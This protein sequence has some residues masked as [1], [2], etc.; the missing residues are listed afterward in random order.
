MEGSG[1]HRRFESFEGNIMSVV[2]ELMQGHS[3]WRNIQDIIR[4]TFKAMAD[5]LR[6][7]SYQIR[8]LEH[9]VAY[10]VSKNEFTSALSH[11]ADILE[12]EDFKD[13][14][15]NLAPYQASLEDKVSRSD[16]QYL[17]TNKASIEEVK[18]MLDKKLSLRDFESHLHSFHSRL[19]E[20]NRK[21]NSLPS[22]KDFQNLNSSIQEKATWADVEEALENKAN[23][24]SVANALHRK[25]N[26]SDAESLLS[27]KAD[28]EAIKELYE[29]IQTKAEKSD[30]EDIELTLDSKADKSE[31][32]AEV[33][34]ELAQKADRN[35]FEALSKDLR[36]YLDKSLMD[37]N[38]VLESYVGAMKS[39]IEEVKKSLNFNLNKKIDSKELEK[40]YNSITKKADFES[41]LEMFEKHKSEVREQ[42]SE[43]ETNTSYLA[44]HQ[45]FI[46]YKVKVDDELNKLN[47]QLKGLM[48]DRRRSSEEV[49]KYI[50]AVNS[51]NKNEVYKQISQINEHLESFDVR[52]DDLVSNR[53]NKEEVNYLKQAVKSLQETKLEPKELQDSMNK[54]Y[55]DLSDHF[56]TSCNK[57]KE[58]IISHEKETGKALEE[59]PNNEEFYKLIDEKLD[60]SKASLWLSDKASHRD[61]EHLKGQVQ[62]IFKAL[63]TKASL[64]TLENHIAT[65]RKAL[66][67]VSKDM[68]QKSNVKDVCELLDTKA[69]VEDANKA[70]SDIHKELDY[71]V[72]TEEFN[73]QINESQ[74]VIEALCTENCIGRW[75]WKSGELKSGNLVPW[76]VQSINT[77][78]D[79]FLWEVEKTSIVCCTPGLYE[80]NF[81]F[82]SRKKPNVQVLV[83]GEPILSA[84]NSASYVVHHSSGRLKGA[85]QHSGGNITGLTLIDFVALPARARVSISYSGDTNVEGFLGLKKL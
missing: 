24:H 8:D 10:K 21:L 39:D 28:K 3:E 41:T 31:L 73:R 50:K 36:S 72:S 60:I 78:P 42:I 32:S 66:E 4:V 35:E 6:T 30:L 23:K 16:L 75:I 9:Q 67:D 63:S 49:Q 80:I 83:N 77:A 14:V 18:A 85:G 48:E 62:D 27:N 22:E 52:I 43:L 51:S 13:T 34:P 37:H 7:Q 26:R 69:N 15:N 82:Y 84:V 70:L 47:E 74:M 2:D 59:K 12:L 19:E 44:K 81:G 40:I 5:V 61:L 11:K 17:L 68:V 53:I 71:K 33:Y 1:L 38:I 56:E 45:E 46:N 20:F 58:R 55:Y 65:T 54:V 76:E 57:L 25:M 79:N 29:L 64:H